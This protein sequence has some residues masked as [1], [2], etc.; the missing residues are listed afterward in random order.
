MLPPSHYHGCIGPRGGRPSRNWLSFRRASGGWLISGQSQRTL[1]VVLPLCSQC[2]ATDRQTGLRPPPALLVAPSPDD[3]PPRR[4]RRPGLGTAPK[5]GRVRAGSG[6][7]GAAPARPP[8]H[9]ARA[10][11]RGL[12]LPC[13][14]LAQH[15]GCVAARPRQLAPTKGAVQR[16][17]RRGGAP[18]PL[19]TATPSPPPT[20]PP[21]PPSHYRR[22]RI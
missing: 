17:W 15:E 9:P 6:P 8:A 3:R 2:A 22:R 18:P 16:G 14:R 10:A 12:L 20:S 7:L 11:S 5:P 19:P 4:P 21:P 13:R 1:P